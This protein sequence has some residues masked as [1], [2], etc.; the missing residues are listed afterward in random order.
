LRGFGPEGE[1]F[2]EFF[3]LRGHSIAFGSALC[4]WASGCFIELCYKINYRKKTW[5]Y[6]M[7]V[8]ATSGL[9]K[10]IPLSEEFRHKIQGEGG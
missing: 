6:S 8:A 1:K 9:W 5:N 3:W 10:C 4:R 2:E 7:Y